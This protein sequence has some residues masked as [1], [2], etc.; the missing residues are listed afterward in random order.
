MQLTA[1]VG[2]AAHRRR[3]LRRQCADRRRAAFLPCA[4]WSRARRPEP[5]P[6]LA[7]LEG[8]AVRLAEGLWVGD[9]YV[10]VRGDGLDDLLVVR[11][12]VPHRAVRP[13]LSR[14]RRG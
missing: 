1:A 6:S 7:G 11:I 5:D 9:A 8:A 10:L 12:A 14:I 3:P 4:R 2:R 13:V